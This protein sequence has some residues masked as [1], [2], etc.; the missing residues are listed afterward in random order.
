MSQHAN[1]HA[2]HLFTLEKRRP[3]E[4]KQ[5]IPQY[6]LQFTLQNSSLVWSHEKKKN[7]YVIN[8]DGPLSM[9]GQFHQS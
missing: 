3:E 8:Y 9:V 1:E 6:K 5:H 2:R 7:S 4:G